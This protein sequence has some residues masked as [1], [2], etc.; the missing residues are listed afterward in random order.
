MRS[1]R[2][3]HIVVHWQPHAEE[4]GAV[5]LMQKYGEEVFPGA[6]Q[7]KV[8]WLLEP[9]KSDV[10]TLDNSYFVGTVRKGGLDEH[11]REEKSAFEIIAK[12]LSLTGHPVW[13]RFMDYVNKADTADARGG[14]SRGGFLNIYSM[15][16]SVYWQ[17]PTS[18]EDGY[19]W[20]RQALEA[21]ESIGENYFKAA[22]GFFKEGRFF[23]LIC[24]MWAAQ[25][26]SRK[27]PRLFDVYGDFF[28]RDGRSDLRFADVLKQVK[29]SRDAIL[30]CDPRGKG[31]GRF[32]S[33]ACRADLTPWSLP[34]MAYAICG[35]RGGGRNAVLAAYRWA[36][37]ALDA[38]YA[39]QNDFRQALKKIRSGDGI[40]TKE[41]EVW[42]GQRKT[43]VF[44]E[45]NQHRST[46][47]ACR[48]HFRERFGLL[49]QTSQQTGT[50]I[51]A[52][53]VLGNPLKNIVSLIRT[54]EGR[55]LG[56]ANGYSLP[57]LMGEGNTCGQDHIYY[58]T[59]SKDGV[60]SNMILNRS[61]TK[62]SLQLM[63]IGWSDLRELVEE[64]L[65][66]N[67]R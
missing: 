42:P 21:V 6:S 66:A 65:V 51:F 41:M 39:R 33:D 17:N 9:E 67:C 53:A 19:Q 58:I 13:G 59:Q 2:K 23:E 40:V 11:G 27:R 60:G 35:K 44:V 48:Y 30:S 24:S 63:K 54:E 16:K 56:K 46:L 31:L 28:P 29:R 15:I 20:C 49:V 22:D 61:E 52:N 45:N 26:F 47:A 50:Q 5:M 4:I 25:K 32:V 43:V 12:K 18:S 62:P 10:Y 64:G 38:F 34:R 7:A 57:E 8:I 14:N 37:V 55:L 1:N 36:K 3:E